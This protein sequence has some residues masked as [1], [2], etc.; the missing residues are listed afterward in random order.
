MD[1][2]TGAFSFTGKYITQR[3]LANGRDVTTLTNHPNRT[4]SFSDE[5]QV[6][7]YRFDD[8]N[9][10]ATS[11]EGAD[12]LYNTFWIRDPQEGAPPGNAVR[13]SRRLVRAAEAADV[14]RIV[15]F[16]VSNADA[17]ALPYY[18][19]K[20]T[21]ERLVEDADLSHA[22]LRPTLVYGTDDLLVNNLAWVLRRSPI[23]AVFGDGDFQ[24]QPVFVGDV[25]DIAV[26]QGAKTVDRTLNVAGPEIYTFEE[27]IRLLVDRLSVRCY[28]V[29]APPQLAYLGIRTIE[30][31]FRDVILMWDEIRGLMNELLITDTQ[32]SGETRFGDWLLTHAHHLG[33]EYT[34]YH[35]RYD[36]SSE[37][38]TP[39]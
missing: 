34:S 31:L 9:V 4:T 26:E 24:V 17:S 7:P 23:F 28:V 27:L 20:A 8:P 39:P 13:F 37:K 21:V 33:G 16:S 29:H 32:P 11:L 18:R 25:A 15:H 10:L 30:V 12:T 14:R 3:L 2:V 22:I 36:P 1:V 19:A 38:T 6:E 5:V 35:G